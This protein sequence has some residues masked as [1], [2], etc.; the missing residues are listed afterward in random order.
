MPGVW[1]RSVLLHAVLCGPPALG[2]SCG[3]VR[4]KLV[5]VPASM[6]LCVV[7]LHCGVVLRKIT[8]ISRV[9]DG[10]RMR[11]CASLKSAMQNRAE[12]GSVGGHL[13]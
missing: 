13:H 2:V 4:E 3:Q 7:V 11:F 9:G 6:H 5:L 12:A 10:I 8:E 1:C